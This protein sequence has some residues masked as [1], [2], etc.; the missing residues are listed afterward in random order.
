M[1]TIRG[2][3]RTDF[4]KLVQVVQNWSRCIELEIAVTTER[5]H[6]QMYSQLVVR[7]EDQ[8]VTSKGATF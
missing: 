6:H 4:K 3:F 7:S 8:S 5:V 2:P 1:K